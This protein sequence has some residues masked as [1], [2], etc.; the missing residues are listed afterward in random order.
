MESTRPRPTGLWPWLWQRV[1]GGLILVFLVA[2][3]S[4][5]HFRHTPSEGI[6]A[7]KVAHGAQVPAIWVLWGVCLGGL[8]LFHGLNGVRNI[9]Y[10]YGLAKRHGRAITAGL[11]LLGCGALAW[12]AWNLATFASLRG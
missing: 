6:T 10:D 1:T 8:C 11:W 9:L 2:H 7:D 4:Y 5:W 12:V 3:L